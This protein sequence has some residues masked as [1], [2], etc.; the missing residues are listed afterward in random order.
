[1]NG[2]YSG[3]IIILTY[4]VPQKDIEQD[5]LITDAGDPILT[6]TGQMILVTEES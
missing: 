1:M 6:N 5:Y 4:G 2:V 3:L